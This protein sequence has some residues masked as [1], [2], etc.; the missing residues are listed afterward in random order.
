M[1]Q[2]YY[3][4]IIWNSTLSHLLSHLLYVLIYVFLQVKCSFWNQILY[5]QTIFNVSYEFTGTLKNMW[6]A[7]RNLVPFAQFKKRE[8]HPR[9]SVTIGKVSGSACNLT[10]SNTPSWSVFHVVSIVLMI[11]NHPKRPVLQELDILQTHVIE[12]L[13]L[14]KVKGFSETALILPCKISQRKY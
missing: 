14:Q 7:S 8:K 12:Y 9:R 10:K 5:L 13:I 11:P 1:D 2:E 6:D 4:S 3:F